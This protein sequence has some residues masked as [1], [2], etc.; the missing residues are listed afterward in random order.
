MEKLDFPA[1]PKRM[2]KVKTVSLRLSLKNGED[3]AHDVTVYMWVSETPT[4]QVMLPDEYARIWHLRYLEESR[5][6]RNWQ[7]SAAKNGEPA[8][9][10]AFSFKDVVEGV[11]RIS[12]LY[13]D[14]QKTAS[15]E[16]VI[17]IS[18][19]LVNSLDHGEDRVVFNKN[20]FDEHDLTLCL[21]ADICYRV[22]QKLF[23]E[24]RMHGSTGP[25]TM[26]DLAE[27]RSYKKV[28]PYSDE[29]WATVEQLQ[30]AMRKA[31]KQLLFLMKS[32]D[33]ELLLKSGNLFLLK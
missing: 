22:N 27:T 8:M 16:K 31:I 25:L 11:Q 4:F 20:S 3:T 7:V 26:D 17:G 6:G 23:T 1:A 5:Y 24:S 21:T 10:E 29:A 13:G 18:A 2:K 14:F 15:I 33:V 28:I 9:V 30:E 12:W 32:E 19:S